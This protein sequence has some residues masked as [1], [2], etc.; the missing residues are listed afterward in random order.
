MEMSFLDKTFCL[1]PNCKNQC[2]RK[3]TIEEHQ[4]LILLKDQGVSYGYF[5]GEPENGCEEIKNE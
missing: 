3:M 4:Q 5:C 2:G 1:S